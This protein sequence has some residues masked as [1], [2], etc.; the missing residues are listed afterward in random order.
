MSIS[1]R[2]ILPYEADELIVRYLLMMSSSTLGPY[3]RSMD[4]SDS[5]LGL[6][7]HTG[8]NPL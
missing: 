7:N 4:S 2:H 5:M 3:W 8:S 6:S 1:F